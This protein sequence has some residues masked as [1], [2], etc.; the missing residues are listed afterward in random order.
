MKTRLES[1][2]EHELADIDESVHIYH[3]RKNLEV[4]NGITIADNRHLSARQVKRDVGRAIDAM[5]VHLTPYSRRYR[6]P[7]IWVRVFLEELGYNGISICSSKDTFSKARGRLIAKGRLLKHL[8]A[9]R[10]GME[11][12]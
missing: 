5:K 2:T 10:G 4:F 12:N 8:V 6:Y 1:K 7:S 11:W 9:L 3:V